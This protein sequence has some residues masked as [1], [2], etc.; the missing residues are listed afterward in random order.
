MIVDDITDRSVLGGA[1]FLRDSMEASFSCPT[2]KSPDPVRIDGLVCSDCHEFDR[3]MT[4]G[5]R[6]TFSEF[7]RSC[8]LCEVA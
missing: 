4:H 5:G 6:W 2:C 8:P 1:D 7:G 3:C